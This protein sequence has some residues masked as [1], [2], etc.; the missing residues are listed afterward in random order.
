MQTIN[1][2]GFVVSAY[3]AGFI[4][5]GVLIAWVMIDYR[6]QRRRLDDLETRGVTRRS[7]AV[8]TEQ[9]V[10]QAEKKA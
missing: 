2:I 3:A 7:A 5:V 6:A 1:H 8:R 10:T 4:V 9:P